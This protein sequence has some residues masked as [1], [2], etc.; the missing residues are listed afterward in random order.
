[1]ELE[2]AGGAMPN[3]KEKGGEELEA[4]PLLGEFDP[5]AVVAEI[6]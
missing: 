5:G 3:P 4:C 6:F 1:M 2:V